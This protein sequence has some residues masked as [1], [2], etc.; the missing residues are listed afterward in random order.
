MSLQQWK[1]L[2]SLLMVTGIM[3]LL[4]GTG[5]YLFSDLAHQGVIGMQVIA[6]TIGAGLLLLIPSKLFL[7]L[8]LMG[9]MDKPKSAQPES[10]EPE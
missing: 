10:R 2:L 9:T 8:L 6:L 7:T 1:F 4:L 5:L 3:L